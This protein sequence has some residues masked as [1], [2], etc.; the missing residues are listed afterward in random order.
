MCWTRGLL[1]LLLLWNTGSAIKGFSQEPTG[2]GTNLYFRIV[3]TIPVICWVPYDVQAIFPRLSNLFNPWSWQKAASI[4]EVGFGNMHIRSIPRVMIK[5]ITQSDHPY[6]WWKYFHLCICKNKPNNTPNSSYLT[7]SSLNH[8]KN[9]S[10]LYESCFLHTSLRRPATPKKYMMALV[11]RQRVP[12][13]NNA[14]IKPIIIAVVFTALAT[15]AVIL[16]LIAKKINRSSLT[17]DDFMIML[18][19]VGSRIV[20]RRI[21]V[22]QIAKMYKSFS[23]TH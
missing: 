15:T 5:S 14:Q 13:R 19:L 20:G 23:F 7:S 8:L 4:I 1:S 6:V 17:I 21:D 12:I 9:Y 2:E 16:R 22:A 3:V 18:A 11:E 10:K